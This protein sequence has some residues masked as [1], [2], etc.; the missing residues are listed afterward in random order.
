MT[1][2]CFS[3]NEILGEIFSQVTDN[4]YEVIPTGI[5]IIA[6]LFS[7]VSVLKVYERSQRSNAKEVFVYPDLT[8]RESRAKVCVCNRSKSYAML[9][10]RVYYLGCSIDPVQ[11][12]VLWGT[13]QQVLPQKKITMDWPVSRDCHYPLTDTYQKRLA[14]NMAGEYINYHIVCL[15]STSSKKRWLKTYDGEFYRYNS[16][17]SS[18]RKWSGIIKK[19]KGEKQR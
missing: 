3:V 19:H 8:K 6:L 4:L 5:S 17:F 10:I 7:I 13:A 12:P 18:L 16:V 1:E 14:D 2:G 9:D 15:Y 11:A